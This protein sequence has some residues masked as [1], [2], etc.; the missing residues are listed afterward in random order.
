MEFE[1]V[2][3]WAI[4]RADGNYTQ[5]G[6]QLPTRDGRKIGNAVVLD[7]NIKTA[8]FSAPLYLIE[9][10]AGTRIRFTEEELR[11]YFHPPEWVMDTSTRPSNGR[12]V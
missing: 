8:G 6:T 9:T 2:P 12:K 7:D 1:H 4:G 10:D 5:V 3:E 11:E